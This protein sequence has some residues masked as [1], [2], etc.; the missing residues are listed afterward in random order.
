MRSRE[1]EEFDPVQLVRDIPDGFSIMAC[2]Q[3]RQG[4]TVLITDWIKHMQPHRK[5][6]EA[7]L[8]SET[9]TAQTDAYQFIPNANRS[10]HLDLG[11]LTEIFEEQAERKKLMSAGRQKEPHRILIIADDVINDKAARDKGT[12]NRLFTQGRHY[13]LDVIVISQTLKGFSPSARTNSDVVACWR[14]LKQ[15]DRASI[16]EDYLMIE[17]GTK[18]ECMRAATQ[19]ANKI[20]S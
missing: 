16:C 4:K 14:C 6:D 19:L 2:A 8:F 17:D 18:K 5:W 13:Y 10:D 3:R 11:K 9:A 15:D 20:S 7:Y 12:F 1:Y